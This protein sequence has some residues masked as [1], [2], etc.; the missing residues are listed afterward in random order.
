VDANPPGSS[1]APALNAI[2]FLSRLWF[3][4]AATR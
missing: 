2:I 1:S 3:Y 4:A